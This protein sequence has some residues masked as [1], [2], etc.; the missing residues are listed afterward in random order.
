LPLVTALLSPEK[1][2][3]IIV[4]ITSLGS[5]ALLG[6]VSARVGSAPVTKAVARVTFWGALAI[7]ATAGIGALFGVVA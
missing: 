6:G 1:L 3:P 5:L 2:I 7:A 4:S